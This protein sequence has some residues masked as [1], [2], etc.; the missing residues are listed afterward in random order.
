DLAFFSSKG[1]TRE[2]RI[3]PDVVAPGT[4]IASVRTQGERLVW[5]DDIE[6]ATVATGTSPARAEW[7]ATAGFQVVRNPAGGA[8][9]GTHAWCLSRSAGSTFQ[10]ILTTPTVRL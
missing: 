8:L 4:W 2:N 3:K 10:D 9:S 7:A 5:R 6:S 1:P